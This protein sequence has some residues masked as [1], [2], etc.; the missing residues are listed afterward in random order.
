MA[1]IEDFYAKILGVL[2]AP[3]QHHRVGSQAATARDAGNKRSVQ[4]GLGEFDT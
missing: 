4:P 3:S 1:R 2:I